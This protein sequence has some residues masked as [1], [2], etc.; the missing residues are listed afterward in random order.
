VALARGRAHG[1]RHL[2]P[3]VRGEAIAPGVARRRPAVSGAATAA[4]LD[5]DIVAAVVDHRIRELRQAG[6]R[7]G[8]EE[9]P[10]TPPVG[11][12][13][14]RARG[15]F[16]PALAVR[17]GLPVCHG[18]AGEQRDRQDQSEQGTPLKDVSMADRSLC[19]S[20]VAG[21]HAEVEAHQ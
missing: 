17:P 6:P 7:A 21:A 4:E 13:C 11:T 9:P 20:A 18:L 3:G 19:I 8:C 12:G 14:G 1:R 5:E 10:G 15:L 2:G 16:A